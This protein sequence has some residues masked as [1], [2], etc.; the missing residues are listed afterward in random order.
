MKKKINKL[1]K[2][3][4]NCGFTKIKKNISYKHKIDILNGI[5]LYY[6]YIKNEK[7]IK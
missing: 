5:K 7:Y 4:S 3:I 1:N 2:K 6:R